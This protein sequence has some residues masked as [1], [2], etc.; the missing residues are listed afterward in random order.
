[1]ATFNLAQSALFALHRLAVGCSPP[2]EAA[3]AG[4][5]PLPAPTGP[6]KT[7]RVSFHW[8][9]ADRAELET[10]APDDKRELMVHLFY[11]ADPG[12]GGER[13]A[14]VPDADAM[15]GPWNAEQ[16]ACITSMRA[17]SRENPALPP[18]NARYP[19]VVFLPGGSMK[20]LTYHVLLEDLASHGWV[21]AAI[22]PPYN[23]RAVRFPDGRVLGNL[24]PDERGWPRPRNAEEN[25]RQY[26]ERIVHWSRDVSF[27]ID[28][29]AALDRENGPF[30][31]RLDLRRGVGVFG[32]SRGGQ[33]AGTVRLLDERVRGGI[34][35]DGTQG[36]YP[37]Q[38][39][40]GEEVSGEQPF[41]WIQK[42]LPPPPTAEQLQRAGR[43]RAEYD[44][45][46]GRI[47]AIW[48][49]KL[50]AVTGGAAHV[51]VARA[52]ITHIDFSDEPFWDGSLTAENR[53][54][55]VRT[56]A[57]TR[58]WVRAFFDGSVRGDWADLKRL[59]AAAGKSQPDVTVQ[60][61]GKMW[62]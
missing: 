40:K 10:K 32:H 60:V 3:Q 53:P 25:R 52:G 29:L 1:M 37:F 46:V 35:I 26:K 54:G 4:A 17:F 16:V 49:R 19:V 61:F 8:K 23:A 57:D 56:I 14:Y 43:T 48:D 13:A 9:D 2:R 50:G 18:G 24:A 28:R 45:E 59:A 39:V 5:E 30:A 11:P 51:T 15:R 36:E 34:N 55:K 22:D 27:V 58:A 31:R 20:A 41:L 62:P 38:P 47:V 33:A 6:H 21:V 7:G 42:P 44:A 12:A